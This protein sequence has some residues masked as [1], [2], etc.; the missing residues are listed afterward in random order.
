MDKKE[1]PN[2]KFE[3]AHLWD[4]FNH[5]LYNEYLKKKQKFKELQLAK[6]N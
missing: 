1:K 2:I 3:K 5:D 6:L 4:Y